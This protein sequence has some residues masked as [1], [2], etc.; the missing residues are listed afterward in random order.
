MP[1][2]KSH[3]R[4]AKRAVKA[5][6]GQKVL[7]ELMSEYAEGVIQGHVSNWVNGVRDVSPYHAVAMELATGAVSRIDFHPKLFVGYKKAA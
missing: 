7:A 2:N 4:L 3:Q 5:V 6:G 1:Q